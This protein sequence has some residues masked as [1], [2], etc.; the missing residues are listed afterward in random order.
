MNE[1]LAIDYL[2]V[3]ATYAVEME[4]QHRRMA[5]AG[6]EHDGLVW[7]RDAYLN[8][9]VMACDYLTDERI[10]DRP[11]SPGFEGYTRKMNVALA[12]AIVRLGRCPSCLVTHD[13][14]ATCGSVSVHSVNT[15]SEES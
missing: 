4:M 5:E 11:L 14:T 6:I 15:P 9:Y 8:A 13:P 3:L 7:S 2:R 10:V 1:Y 12:H